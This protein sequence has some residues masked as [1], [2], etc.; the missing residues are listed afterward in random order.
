MRKDL[1][2]GFKLTDIEQKMTKAHYGTL[3]NRLKQQKV[4]PPEEHKCNFCQNVKLQDYRI[5]M[6]K[7]NKL[8]LSDFYKCKHR[9]QIRQLEKED[10]EDAPRRK[11][12]ESYVDEI[13]TREFISTKTFYLKMKNVYGCDQREAENFNLSPENKRVEEPFDIDESAKALA[14]QMR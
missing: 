10:E 4:N 13:E 9:D 6:E 7:M 2:Y 8:F 3:V 1:N 14:E 12:L 5:P 11:A